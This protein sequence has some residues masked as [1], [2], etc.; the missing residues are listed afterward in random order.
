MLS[1]KN[2]WTGGDKQLLSL[3]I[4]AG[5][6]S[7]ESERQ[8]METALQLKE[9]PIDYFR[10]GIWKPRT[11][12][13][14]FEGVGIEGLSWLQKVQKELKLKVM[15]EVANAKHI[16][17][18]LKYNIDAIW[19]GARTSANPFAIQEIA[20]AL[21]GLDIPV[22]I[23]NPVNP[24]AELWIGAIER[25][26][27]AGISKIVAI[28]RGFSVF[29]KSNYRNAPQ[30]Q[31]PIELRQKMPEVPIICDPSHICGKTET[32]YEISQKALDLNFEGLIIEV[33]H[34]PPKALS[35][36][37]QQ[38]K[39]EELKGL[40]E[41]LVVRTQ[42][43]KNTDVINILEDLRQKIDFLDEELLQLL[44]QR[45]QLVENIGKYKKRHRI[46]I[47]QSERWRHILEKSISSGTVKNLS[48]EFISSLFKAIHQESINKQT[49]IMNND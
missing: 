9:L 48:E 10:A 49:Q 47:L 33:H 20:D 19:I 16:E 7:A 43:V 27:N 14:S 8:L 39:P 29:N 40:L 28:H 4:I 3:M 18:I 13:F 41:K 26:R 38:I 25:I 31:V 23:K 22:F 2:I 30:W 24:D 37:Q 36:A 15:T 34:N 12:P 32:L 6:C 45:M 46:T 44:A 5:P 21:K 42:Q 17:E 11:R 1:E 35:D